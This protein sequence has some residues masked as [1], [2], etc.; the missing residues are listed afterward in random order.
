MG[1]AFLDVLEA[2]DISVGGVGVNVPHG[3]EGCNI[4]AAVQV[5]IKLP[6]KKAFLAKAVVRHVNTA[7]CLFGVE[8][9]HIAERHRVE[10]ASYVEQM[11]ELGRSR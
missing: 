2:R 3:F 8:F 5:I 6:G 7:M 9:T 11:I 4:R 1:A 10:I